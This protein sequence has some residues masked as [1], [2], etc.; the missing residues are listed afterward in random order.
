MWQ[1]IHGD[2]GKVV[3]TLEANSFDAVLSDPPYG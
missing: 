2:V 3:K 1:I